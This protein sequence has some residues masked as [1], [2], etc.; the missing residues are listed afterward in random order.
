MRHGSESKTLRQHRPPIE[1]AGVPEVSEF[2]QQ[3]V[4]S[5]I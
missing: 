5:V 1:E 4:D 3:I 2:L